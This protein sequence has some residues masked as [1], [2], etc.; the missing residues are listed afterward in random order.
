MLQALLKN[1][2]RKIP[3][4]TEIRDSEEEFLEKSQAHLEQLED[5]RQEKFRVYQWRKRI[6]IP[7]GVLLTPLLG[8]VDYWLLMIQTGDDRGAGL[9]LAVLG[10]LYAWVT[11][12]KRQY[13]KAYKREILPKL[14]Q[15]FG[16][17]R[18]EMNGRISMLA[19]E[20]S[21]ILPA[22]DKYEAE[23]YFVGTYKGVDIEFSEVDFKQRRR[24]KNRTRY[25]SVFKGLAIML[26]MNTK[27]FY[28]H[29]MLDKDRGKVSE[30]FKQRSSKLKRAN[31][32]DPEFEKVFDVYTNDQ[33]EARYLI[34]PVMMERLRGLQEEYDGENMTAAFYD[35][36][37]LILIQSPYNYFEP[38]DIT[39]PATD[40]RSI[41]SMKKEIGEILGLI[42]RLNL[43][44][45]TQVHPEKAV[46]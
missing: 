14:A 41:L 26:D 10:G 30:W 12:P 38:A 31:L 25:V 16:D 2:V 27:R 23:D 37:M 35:S 4:V 40:P 17:F 28:G 15:L 5:I 7:V 43:Y 8:F 22:H 36:Q 9:T 32:V 33:V 24:S 42:D 20:A 18:Y 6:A 19:M 3:E 11:H 45:P 1:K 39:I 46:M 13:A 34:D 44:D 29:T 21:K